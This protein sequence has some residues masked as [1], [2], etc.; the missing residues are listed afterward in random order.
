VE[1][2]NSF[3]A[4]F[5]STASFIAHY[6]GYFAFGFFVLLL[7]FFRFRP[8]RKY[9]FVKHFVVSV[10][11]LVG[12]ITGGFLGGYLFLF[13]IAF[14]HVN[15]LA[16]FV[17]IDPHLAGIENDR[18]A[19]VRG[20][21]K[22][23]RPARIMSYTSESGNLV[24]AAATAASGSD[25]FYGGYVLPSLPES[26]ILAVDKS[27]SRV[28]L[29][30]NTLILSGI[31]PTDLQEISPF[32]GFSLARSYFPTRKIRAYPKIRV[33]GRKEYL[34]YRRADVAE[35]LRRVDLE[36]EKTEVIIA[37]LSAGIAADTNAVTKK[38]GEIL[39]S[40]YKAFEAFYKAQKRR[41][42]TLASSA[43]RELGLFM[44]PDVIRIVVDDRVEQPDVLDLMSAVVH[45]YLHYAS[46]VSDEKRFVS[47]FFEEGLTEYF[48]RAAL[49]DE[50]VS[51]SH[52]AYP[53]HVV[54]VEEM[55]QKIPES[56]LEE[57]YFRKDEDELE[58]VMDRAYGE[59][60]YRD[61][62]VLFDDLQYATDP[63]QALRIANEIMNKI[64]GR[65]LD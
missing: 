64:G 11:K 20:L 2:T 63:V 22:N 42:E 19:I 60:F 5:Y 14:I 40:R 7:I 32:F 44:P 10:S 54:V 15:I 65:R 51:H 3:Y 8:T 38:Q 48:A 52:L 57:I 30:D 47:T 41:G 61:N 6:S 35:K 34:A 37:S 17:N 46:Y 27:L 56:E 39:L 1:S 28:I 24:A 9:S 33:I 50:L 31:T 59:G 58:R 13:F 4:Y 43:Y 62:L 18:K 16:V 21:Q 45:E 55:M 53:L 29:V 12:V 26:V 23:S 49:R 36:I 25:N